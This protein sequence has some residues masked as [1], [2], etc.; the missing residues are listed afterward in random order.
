M[1]WAARHGHQQQGV[2]GTSTNRSHGAVPQG[3]DHGPHRI[4]TRRIEV[5]GHER[6][7]TRTSATARARIGHAPIGH[8]R[9]TCAR[10]T[11]ARIACARIACARIA[12]ARVTCARVTCARIRR[13]SVGHTCVPASAGP[14]ILVHDGIGADLDVVDDGCV[15]QVD[16]PH[17]VEGEDASGRD[18]DPMLEA[19]HRDI[20]GSPGMGLQGPL[21]SSARHTQSLHPAIEGGL[22]PLGRLASDGGSREHKLG[23]A[24]RIGIKPHPVAR[25][26]LND[27]PMA[28][29]ALGRIAIELQLDGEVVIRKRLHG[30]QR[31]VLLVPKFVLGPT[32]DVQQ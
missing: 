8:T 10:V 3:I 13:P 28:L 16:V 32:G 1:L 5:V 7:S 4:E 30:A 29:I 12:C 26:L 22:E 23:V 9:V 24:I 20:A 2:P 11:C 19:T 6:A 25:V 27:Q 15:V 17:S 21:V 18:R 14:A 31:V